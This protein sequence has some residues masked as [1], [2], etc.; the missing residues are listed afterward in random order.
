MATPDDL[1]DD[2]YYKMLCDDIYEV[3]KSYIL[4]F[5]NYFFK[6]FEQKI[7]CFFS[8]FNWK[9]CSKYGNVEKVEI[10]RPDLNTG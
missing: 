6:F 4:S 7:L 9:E 2:E 1:V 5:F 10:P 3:K 8:F